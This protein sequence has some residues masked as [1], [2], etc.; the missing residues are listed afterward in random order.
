M[1]GYSIDAE[2]N[3][4]ISEFIRDE[5]LKVKL[6]AQYDNPLSFKE[7]RSYELKIVSIQGREYTIVVNFSG[8]LVK[9]TLQYIVI[10]GLDISERKESERIVRQ[11][12]KSEIAANKAKSSFLANMSYEIRT[13]LNAIIGMSYLMLDTTLNDEQLD[14]IET[15]KISSDALLSII[16]DILDYSKIEAGKLELESVPF[17]I[18][19]LVEEVLE[20]L[21]RANY[22]VILMDIQMPIMDGIIAS[23]KVREL[24]TTIKQPYIIALTAHA[25]ADQL[26]QLV[27]EDMNDFITKPIAI[28][29]LRRGL[30]RAYE[31][32]K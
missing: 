13:P 8:I 24:G 25:I 10:T 28:S 12:M 17:E 19:N 2:V 6:K 9:N 27:T 1:L 18:T 22:N 30:E 32:T 4:E 7:A 20:M 3:A 11:A 5:E 29:T 14:F 15:I 21:P 23:R 16:N 31:K 26:N